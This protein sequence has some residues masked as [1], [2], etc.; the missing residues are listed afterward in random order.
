MS[1]KHVERVCQYMGLCLDVFT[2]AVNLGL[3]QILYLFIYVI[4]SVC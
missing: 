3:V 4:E 1:K 2:V